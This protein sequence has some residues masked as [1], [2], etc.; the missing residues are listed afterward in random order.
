MTYGIFFGL[1]YFAF[2]DGQRFVSLATLLKPCPCNVRLDK[3]LSFYVVCC[4]AELLLS[5][6]SHNAE[7]GALRVSLRYC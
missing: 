1:A 3:S 6:S 2:D 4:D 7:K 5:R